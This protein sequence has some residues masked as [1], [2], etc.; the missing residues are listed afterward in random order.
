[1][2]K[3][4]NDSCLNIVILVLLILIIFKLLNISSENFTV[5][6]RKMDKIVKKNKYDTYV[7]G[8]MYLYG[9]IH[10]NDPN[11]K[12]NY[13]YLQNHTSN[14]NVN[15]LRLTINNN[16]NEKFEIWGNS[17]KSVQGCKGPGEKAHSFDA[18][19]KASHKELCLKRNDGT[20]SCINAKVFTD[21]ITGTNNLL[22]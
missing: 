20:Y 11:S 19:G 14:N 7:D 18:Q 5:K 6:K 4:N 16:P 3:F 2:I 21:I 12:E 17:C 15:S 22:K 9:K 10:F 8:D 1:M 13:Y